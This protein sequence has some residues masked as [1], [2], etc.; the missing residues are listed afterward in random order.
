MFSTIQSHLTGNWGAQK[1]A[2]GLDYVIGMSEVRWEHGYV[3]VLLHCCCC[4]YSCCQGLLFAH[5]ARMPL[6]YIC[7]VYHA[8]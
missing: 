7:I 4:G 6:R 3:L 2:V 5:S 1:G 8:M